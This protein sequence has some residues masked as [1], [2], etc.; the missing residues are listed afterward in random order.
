MRR[1]SHARERVL[2]VQPRLT[3]PGGGNGVCAWIIEALRD[4]YSVDLLTWDGVDFAELNRYFG[5]SLAP[6]DVRLLRPPRPLRATVDASSASLG[7]LRA[8]LLLRECRRT[9]NLLMKVQAK[10]GDCLGCTTYYHSVRTR[11]PQ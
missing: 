7:L 11:T 1:P 3:P 8:A 2:V 4:D 10:S 6:E 5:T 9:S